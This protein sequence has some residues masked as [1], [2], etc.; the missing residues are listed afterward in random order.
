MTTVD[1]NNIGYKDEPFV[2]AKNVN[3][4]FYVKDMSTNPKR[5]KNNNDPINEPKR[6]IV[7]S[8]KRNIVRIE[9]KSDISE[10]YEKDDR[11]PPFTVNSNPS[12][13]LNN[14][15]TLWLRR[16]HNQG[17]YVKK[18]IAILA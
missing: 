12:I 14:E 15:D 2:L 9:D 18:F 5:G 4:V 1:L 16:D 3:Q 11:I 13:L 17:T 8:G 7:L 6:H 10:D